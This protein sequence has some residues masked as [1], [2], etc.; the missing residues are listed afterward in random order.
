MVGAPATDQADPVRVRASGFSFGV[1]SQFV[2]DGTQRPL[3][4][5]ALVPG[6]VDEHGRLLPTNVVRRKALL[7]RI[8]AEE[9]AI[10]TARSGRL[11]PIARG[12]RDARRLS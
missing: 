5:P 3:S 8:S 2:G 10:E 7:G 4:D 11:S 12:A 9:I 1:H 6:L